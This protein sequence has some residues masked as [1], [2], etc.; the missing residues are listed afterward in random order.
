FGTFRKSQDQLLLIPEEAVG[1]VWVSGDPAPS[2]PR[3]TNHRYGAEQV[4]RQPVDR[5][6]QL[7]F[8]AVHDHRGVDRKG[9]GMVGHEESASLTR[10]LLPPLPPNSEPVAVH[11]AVETA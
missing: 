2:R 9:T 6:A 10:D 5:P 3:R 8:D 1:V 4:I 11:R 7:L